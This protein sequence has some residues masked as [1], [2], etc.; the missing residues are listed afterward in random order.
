MNNLIKND[1]R[2]LII[3]HN[4]MA[5]NT[6]MGKTISSYFQS[7]NKNN[8]AQL[9]FHSEIPTSRCCEKYYRFTDIDALKSVL[10][11]CHHGQVFG[12]DDI[13]DLRDDAVEMGKY[14]NVYNFGRKRSPLIYLLRDTMWRI[15][16]W[17]SRNLFLWIESFSPNVIFFASGDY[18]FSYRITEYISKKYNIPVIACCVD[19]YYLYNENQ[20][21][22]LGKIRYKLFMENVKRCFERAKYIFTISEEMSCE[23]SKLFGKICPILYTGARD[24]SNIEKQKYIHPSISYLGGLSLGRY[25]QLIDIGKSL[26]SINNP[27]VPKYLDVYSAET[28]PEIIKKMNAD[29]GINFHGK[30]SGDEVLEIIV[31]S[32]AIVH[33]ESFDTEIMQ[34][35]KYSISTKIPDS[36]AS[37]T[38]ILAYGPRGIAS[39]DYLYR[40][41]A[42]MV[43]E[44]EKD[45]VVSIKNIF[46]N[47]ELREQIEKNAIELSKKNHSAEKVNDVVK[48][49]INL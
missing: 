1:T 18:S 7:W 31:R 28:N 35:V 24:L 6:S 37:G 38:C 12:Q 44:N 29:N 17:K 32:T 23:Y 10:K 16:S 22:L 36:L 13:Q 21:S 43:V 4:V 47:I 42:A 39:I 30:V 49:Y 15:S 27:L 5:K 2:V 46:E 19:D 8:I 34:R 14:S 11:R 26:K 48:K 33:T 20:K 45:L 3:S 9:F 25:K 41:N 40:N